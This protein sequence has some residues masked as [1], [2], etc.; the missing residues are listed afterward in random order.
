MTRTDIPG[1]GSTTPWRRKKCLSAGGGCKVRPFYGVPGS[2]NPEFCAR[3]A[4]GGLIDLRVSRRSRSSSSSSSSGGGGRSGDGGEATAQ[5]GRS[6]KPGSS[7]AC[8]HRGCPTRPTYGAKGATAR[9][10]CSKHAEPGM[11]DVTTRRCKQ[12]DCTKRASFGVEGG[13]EKSAE[14]CF[15]H[16]LPCMVNVRSKRCAHAGCKTRPIFAA[17]RSAKG[18]FCAAHAAPGMVDV[19]N[20]KCQQPGGC[21]KQPSYGKEGDKKASFCSEHAQAGLV[22]IVSIRCAREG[23]VKHAAYGLPGGGKARTSC[24]GHA[25]P[26]M[27]LI[28]SLP[29]TTPQNRR[30]RRSGD[31]HLSNRSHSPSTSCCT[32]ISHSRIGSVTGQASPRLRLLLSSPEQHATATTMGCLVPTLAVQASG[33][34]ETLLELPML[35]LL[36]LLLLLLKMLLLLLLLK[37]SIHKL[38]LLLL[39]LLERLLLLLLLKHP[40]HKLLL[41]LLLLLLQ[42][43]LLPSFH[44]RLHSDVGAT[45]PPQSPPVLGSSTSSP[46][47]ADNFAITPQDPTA[48]LQQF[49]T[50][51]CSW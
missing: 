13:T 11:V 9:E 40:I 29:T 32:I 22:N 41:L 31:S 47:S 35:I 2:G 39:L 38:V 37:Y 3:H 44:S 10:Y 1:A 15:G 7:R 12:E 48:P 24:L 51:S 30:R 14:F 18:E 4:H 34:A 16:A 45:G 26:G 6:R 20:R 28:G 5:Q 17:A 23:C 49:Q 36:L 8:S 19:V 42:T 50:V 25:G 21:P 27:V 46:L 33:I 43:L